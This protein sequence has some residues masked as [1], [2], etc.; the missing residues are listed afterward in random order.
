MRT[1]TAVGFTTK[2]RLW[3]GLGRTAAEMTKA[4]VNPTSLS[5]F[6]FDFQDSIMPG[7]GVLGGH[8]D[9]LLGVRSLLEGLLMS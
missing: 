3:R 9:E 8:W 5:L 7:Y 2:E 6:C 4:G 1:E